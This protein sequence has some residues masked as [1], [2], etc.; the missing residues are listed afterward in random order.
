M[1]CAGRGNVVVFRVGGVATAQCCSDRRPWPGLR[2]TK[3]FARFS[4]DALFLTRRQFEENKNSL[5]VVLVVASSKRS[6]VGGGSASR[7]PLRG[8]QP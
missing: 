3:N 8:S 7:S 2:E 4:L 1:L 5:A 6:S